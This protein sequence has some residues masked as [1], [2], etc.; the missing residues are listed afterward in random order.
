[1]SATVTR[2]KA[3]AMQVCVPADW[4]DE[5]IVEFAEEENPCGTD[6]GWHV[7]E[8]GAVELAGDADRVNC[9]QMPG[10]VHVVLGC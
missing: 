4:T 3:L 2:T 10:H 5:R 8:L 9:A 1:M 7:C 6:Y